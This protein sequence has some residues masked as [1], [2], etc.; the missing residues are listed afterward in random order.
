MSEPGFLLTEPLMAFCEPWGS[1]Y[2]ASVC[3]QSVFGCSLDQRL[4]QKRDFVPTGCCSASV[5]AVAALSHKGFMSLLP[6]FSSFKV[7]VMSELCAL[8]WG[9]AAFTPWVTLL[10]KVL[11]I[12]PTKK[13]WWLLLMQRQKRGH[14][15]TDVPHVQFALLVLLGW[16]LRGLCE[17]HW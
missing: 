6:C 14:P 12:R 2:N 10:V 13:T 5:P 1:L 9:S 8:S 7:V 17:V 4:R 11:C 15:V 3:L 16:W